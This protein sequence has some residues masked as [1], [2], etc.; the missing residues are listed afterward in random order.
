MEEA[1]EAQAELCRVHRIG[2]FIE[3]FPLAIQ[4]QADEFRPVLKRFVS[5]YCLLLISHVRVQTTN[6]FTFVNLLIIY[7]N[8][9]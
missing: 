6:K 5:E 1:V 9:N 7:V 4:N 2:V 8:P 3:V